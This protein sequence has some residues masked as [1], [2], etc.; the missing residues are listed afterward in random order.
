[1]TVTGSNIVSIDNVTLTCAVTASPM[2]ALDPPTCNAFGAPDSN[3]MAPNIINLTTANETTGGNATMTVA[4]TPK[5]SG[6]FRPTSRPLGPNWFLVGEVGAFIACFLLLGI[7]AQK[8]RG[9]VLLAMLIF[10]VIAVGTSCGSPNN[11]SIS[12]NPG[13]TIGMYTITV[14]ATPVSGAAQTTAIT[15]NVQ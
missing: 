6:V 2:G 5:T 8:R 3:F 4:T 10:A 1:M 12:G 15:V 11:I 13:T 7:S 9:L 14:T